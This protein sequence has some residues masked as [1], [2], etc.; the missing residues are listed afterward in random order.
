MWAAQPDLLA[1]ETIP[2]AVEAEALVDVLEE[3]GDALAWV[4][5]TC[6][7]GEHLAD[8]SSFDEVVAIADAAPQVVAI[9]VNCTAPPYVPGLVRRAAAA[10][11]KPIVAYPNRGGIWDATTKSWTGDDVPEGFG[12]LAA[13]LRTAGARAIGGCCGTGPSD[14]GAIAELLQTPDPKG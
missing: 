12:S 5:F 9:G 8:G 1:I 2:S 4:S 11:A 13:T 3:I 10:T 14:I 7:D 6:A